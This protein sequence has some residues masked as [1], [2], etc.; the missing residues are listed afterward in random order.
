[1]KCT[2]CQEESEY[3]AI[4]GYLCAKH[5]EEKIDYKKDRVFLSI[6]ENGFK[7]HYSENNLL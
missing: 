2:F 4:I 6:F 3:V 1:M 7:T 5:K